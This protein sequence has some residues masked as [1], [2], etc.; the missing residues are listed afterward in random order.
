MVLVLRCNKSLKGHTYSLL[1]IVFSKFKILQ[2][3]Y[4]KDIV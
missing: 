4:M 1:A 2:E 3:I